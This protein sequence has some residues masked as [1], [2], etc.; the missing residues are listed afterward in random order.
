MRPTRMRELTLINSGMGSAEAGHW[1]VMSEKTKRIH[2]IISEA[3]AA[4][5]I[6][7]ILSRS[8]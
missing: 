8:S 6:L 1:S 3:R 7:S 5:D 2:T 4:D